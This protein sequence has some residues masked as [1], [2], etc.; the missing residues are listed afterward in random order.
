MDLADLDLTAAADSG[1]DC[2]LEHPVTG[3]PLLTDDGKPLIIRVLGADS[4]EF[5][6]TM[7]RI[8]MKNVGKKRQ[9]LEGAETNAIELLASVT[10][11]WSNIVYNGEPLKFTPEN[12]RKLYRERKWIRE[13]VDVFIADRGN[14]LTSAATS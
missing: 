7:S 8:S 14:F 12:V 11:G 5:R 1:A 10:T 3:E 9:T 2:H 6:Q 4:R 13:Q